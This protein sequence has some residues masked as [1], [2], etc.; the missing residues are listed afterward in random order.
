[1]ELKGVNTETK[2]VILLH[3]IHLVHLISKISHYQKL[4]INKCTKKCIVAD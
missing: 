3:M 1:M 2:L 4:V